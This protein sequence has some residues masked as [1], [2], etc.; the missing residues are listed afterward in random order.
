VRLEDPSSTAERRARGHERQRQG[1]GVPTSTTTATSRSRLR[2][3]AYNT[4]SFTVNGTTTAPGP[5]VRRRDAGAVGGRAA[6]V[7]GLS[8]LPHG[9]VAQLKWPEVMRACA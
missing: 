2:G 1:V 7:R 9:N 6:A 4:P 5:A 3:G 8:L